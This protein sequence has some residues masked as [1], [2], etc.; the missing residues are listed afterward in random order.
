MAPAL[1]IEERFVGEEPFD[2][3]TRQYNEEMKKILPLYNIKVTEIPRLKIDNME[4]SASRV[5]NLM[6]EGKWEE[7]RKWVTGAVY[8]RLKNYEN[9]GCK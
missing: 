6:R 1:G 5:R 7:I 9:G 3:V 4:I 2:M 8:D